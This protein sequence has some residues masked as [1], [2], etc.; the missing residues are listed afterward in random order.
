MTG[1]I[2]SGGYFLGGFCLGDFARLHCIT[3]PTFTITIYYYYHSIVVISV[4]LLSAAGAF[5]VC[6]HFY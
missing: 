5:V 4:G 6:R 2:L 1:G 3:F